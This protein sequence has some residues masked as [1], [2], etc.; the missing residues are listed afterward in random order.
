MPHTRGEIL[1][2]Q[3]GSSQIIHVMIEELSHSPH[4]ELYYLQ[5]IVLCIPHPTP[6]S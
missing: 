5:H 4:E 2:P 1:D 3:M 6:E